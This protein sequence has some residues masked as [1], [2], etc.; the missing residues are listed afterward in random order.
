MIFINTYMDFFGTVTNFPYKELVAQASN[1]QFLNELRLMKPDCLIDVESA[2]L[3]H[4][5]NISKMDFH[6]IY[7][8]FY[9]GIWQ[10]PVK[11][12]Y[13][14]HNNNLW[15]NATKYECIH[16]FFILLTAIIFKFEKFNEAHIELLVN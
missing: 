6:S 7:K 13:W 15:A 1:Q 11:G 2:N 10:E 16:F 3:V 5:S 12:M 9:D 4:F 8:L 14:K